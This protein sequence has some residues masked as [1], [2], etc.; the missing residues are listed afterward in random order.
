LIS[1]HCQHKASI[2]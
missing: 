1:S 2:P